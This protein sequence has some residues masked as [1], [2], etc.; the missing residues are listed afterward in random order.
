MELKQAQLDVDRSF[1]SKL[2]SLLL[3]EEMPRAKEMRK[4]LYAVI[5]HVFKHHPHLHYYQVA[6][7]VPLIVRV[8]MM[9]VHS[10]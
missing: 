5:A 2:I 8:S 3:M 4:G 9:F 7:M 1:G 10:S 6:M